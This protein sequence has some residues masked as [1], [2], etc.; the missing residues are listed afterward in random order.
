MFVACRSKEGSDECSLYF[1]GA[2]LEKRKLHRTFLFFSGAETG[3][4][5]AFAI[6]ARKVQCKFAVSVRKA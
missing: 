1:L 4:G 5:L 6:R 2:R 3:G